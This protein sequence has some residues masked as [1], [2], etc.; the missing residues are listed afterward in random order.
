MQLSFK[1]AFKRCKIRQKSSWKTWFFAL[2]VACSCSQACICAHMHTQLCSA[3]NNVWFVNI[4]YW[5]PSHTH[6]HS[7]YLQAAVSG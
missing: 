2:Y 3:D 7:E 1:Y 5:K 6:T 4:W